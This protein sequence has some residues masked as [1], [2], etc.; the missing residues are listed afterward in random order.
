V[1]QTIHYHPKA[2]EKGHVRKSRVGPGSISTG[3]DLGSVIHVVLSEIHEGYKRIR[4]VL[5]ERCCHRA[6]GRV[7]SLHQGPKRL[8]CEAVKVK[9]GFFF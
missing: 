2:G 4:A 6:C 9:P 3:G 7:R 1:A 5:K 8:L